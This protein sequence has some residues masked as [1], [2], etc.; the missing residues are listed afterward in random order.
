M[1]VLLL[2]HIVR[3]K[4]NHRLHDREV[5]MKKLSCGML[6]MCVSLFFMAGI[7]L[8]VPPVK[9]VTPPTTA[10]IKTVHPKIEVRIAEI[11]RVDDSTVAFNGDRIVN[12]AIRNKS[13]KYVF[14]S[15]ELFL[16][17]YELPLGGGRR[18]ICQRE[19]LK[20][21]IR[22]GHAV[23]FKKQLRR[24]ACT[25]EYEI[26]L[27]DTKSQQITQHYIGHAGSLNRVEL[28]N[29]TF[30]KATKRW[31][32]DMTCISR[33]PVVA[34][35]LYH[36]V[37]KTDYHLISRKTGVIPAGKVRKFGGIHTN[38]KHGDALVVKVY[39]DE[40][41]SCHCSN[42]KRLLGQAAITYLY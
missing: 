38:F 16:E 33:V 35:A 1:M 28:S 24:C 22:P 15:H 27:W 11:T 21:R 34:T 36:R 31:S 26:L 2:N 30:D 23:Y 13:P 37:G 20:R 17:M 39:Y 7:T 12:V 8:A 6:T 29:L 25:V 19:P 18:L 40:P 3:L 42:A 32:V 9:K 4:S 10:A 41:D 5:I 14:Q